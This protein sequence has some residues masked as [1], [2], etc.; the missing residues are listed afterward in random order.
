MKELQASP[1]TVV[2]GATGLIGRWLVPELTKRGK[3][4]VVLMRRAKEREGDY[5]DWV[6]KRGGF[7]SQVIVREVNLKQKDLGIH[8]NEYKEVREVYHLA[9]SY[10][11]GLSRE[12]A[13]SINVQGSLNVL[14]WAKQLPLLRHFIMVSGY[15][16][17]SEKDGLEVLE[18]K[19]LDKLYKKMGAYE[20]SKHE[21]NIRMKIAA[22]ELQL[23]LTIVN[24]SSVIGDSQTGETTQYIGLAET[25]RDLFHGKMPAQVGSSEIFVPVVS[26]DYV[27]K[28]MARL[29]DFPESIGHSYWLLDDD[30]PNLSE[31][32]KIVCEHL[33]IHYPT[34][35][36][37]LGLVKALPKF[38]TKVEP[39][40]LSFLST[41]RYDTRS[42]Q[43]LAQKMMLQMPD[44]MQTLHKWLDFLISTNFGAFKPQQLGKFQV[45]QQN[46]TFLKGEEQKPELVFLHGIPLDSESWQEV[47]SQNER[48]SLLVDLPGLGRNTQDSQKPEDWMDSLFANIQTKP[49]IIG[50]SWGCE[51]ALRHAIQHPESVSSLVL[52]S[53][54]FLQA[55]PSWLMRNQ[56]I[57][58]FAF[59]MTDPKTL[60]KKLL[61]DKAKMTPAMHSA[62]QN[63]MRSGGAGRIAKALAKAGKA[64]NR[65]ELR[66]LL[67][68]VQVP[69]HIIAG[70]RDALLYETGNAKVSIIPDTGHYPQL[71]HAEQVSG[72]LAEGK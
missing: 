34:L 5:L 37:P 23:P 49:T 10:A 63:L 68:Q 2:T 40:A 21:E 26:V 32:L 13:H 6:Q 1:D 69:V 9:A 33:G 30:T 29:P 11:F 27:V 70:E 3:T 71:T 42:A 12:D 67:A 56:T 35:R 66:D 50:H 43:E 19:S 31:L 46:A 15:R 14:H 53:P 20:A 24:P 38:I 44:F 57:M 36:L 62:V 64:K 60:P 61:G 39:E 8:L 52:I 41:D 22:Q 28:F 55:R 59:Q 47:L 18:K 51:F 25:V 48:P 58:R 7:S 72:L 45:T 65:K 4:V 17:G 16:V 54:F